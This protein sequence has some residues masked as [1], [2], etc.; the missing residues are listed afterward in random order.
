VGS[1]DN[2]IYHNRFENN[3]QN[4]RDMG[5]NVWDNGYP[6]G[7]NYWDDYTG[8][9]NDGDDIG[10][11]PYDIP[12]KDPPNQDRYPLVGSQNQQPTAYIN[13]IS[14]NPA[15]QG[16][17]VYFDGHG[18]D[19]GR[20]IGWEWQSDL[21]GVLSYSEDFSTSTLSVGT[22]TIRFKVK[23]KDEQWSSY[24]VDT[25]VINSQSTANQKPTAE[26]VSVKPS[27]VIAGEYVYFHGFGKDPDG[28]VVEYSWRS[29]VDGVLS[30]SSTFNTSNLTVGTHTIYFK[31]KDDSGEWS[32]EVSTEVVVNPNASTP[33][34]KYPVA[35]AGGLYSCYVDEKISLIGSGSY[36]E[37]GTII[38]YFW[39]FGDGT[40]GRGVSPTHIYSRPGNYTVVLTVKDDSGSIA[41]DVTYVN[42]VQKTSQGSSGS[43]SGGSLGFEIQIPFI[44]IFE[45][46]FITFAILM[47]L[48]WIKRK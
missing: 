34:N 12:G 31:V 9:D 44:V 29:S 43:S 20:I 13:S 16:E 33:V 1:S 4:A 35:N 23:D 27:N 17:T 30:D 21:D 37:D 38:E 22:H 41:S 48:L 2:R 8:V 32:D 3:D 28:M 46:I 19:D 10:D 7:G 26:I 14:P 39:D 36:D 40:I 45:I 5:S 6:S 47:F 25:L 24:A 42:V 18:T 11:T 15:V